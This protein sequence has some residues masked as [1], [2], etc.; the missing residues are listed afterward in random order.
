MNLI[1]R[2]RLFALLCLLLPAA[3]LADEPLPGMLSLEYT[4]NR[5]GHELGAVTR[6][7]QRTAGGS[8]MHT[9]WM[10]ATGLAGLLYHTEWREDGEFVVEGGHILPQRFAEIRTGDKRAYEHRVRIDRGQ[11]LLVLGR[12]KIALPA[13]LQDQGSLVYALMLDPLLTPGERTVTVTDG[14]DV[15]AYV[16]VYRGRESISTPLGTFESVVIRRVTPKQREQEA[17]CKRETLPADACQP[18][19]FTFWLAPGKR[20]APVKLERRR[21]DETT[22]M[23][24]RE[25]R[26]L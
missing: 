4:L 12:Q 17:R 26:G 5:N 19:D 18:D 3:L 9:L 1:K 6:T 21:K 2:L 14:K 7:L 20:Y 23:F 11:K 25:A 15:T 16:L 24:L 8:Y 22:T 10:R 13:G